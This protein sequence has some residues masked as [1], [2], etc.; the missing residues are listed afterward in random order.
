MQM[1][2]ATQ[3]AA[4]RLESQ[5]AKVEALM[6]DDTANGIT[7]DYA[8]VIDGKALLYALSPRLRATFLQARLGI[9]HLFSLPQYSLVLLRHTCMGHYAAL[10]SLA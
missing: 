7:M 2:E 3:I 4:E 10:H 8:L 5:L 9:Q 1:E 6:E